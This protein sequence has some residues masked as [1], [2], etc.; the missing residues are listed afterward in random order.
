MLVDFY[1]VLGVAPTA[2]AAQVRAAYQAAALASHPDKAGCTG[3]ARFQWVQRAWEVLREER[4]RAEYDTARGTELGHVSEEVRAEDMDGAE[5]GEG[6]RW[7]CRCGGAF[8]L[9]VVALIP[10]LGDGSNHVA[11]IVSCDGCSLRIRVL[12][13]PV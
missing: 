12:G 10:C 1:E 4:S 8:T 13:P 2:S 9:P 5:E 7:A 11:V 3:A 6:L